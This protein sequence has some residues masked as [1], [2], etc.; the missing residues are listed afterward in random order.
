MWSGV[1]EVHKCTNVAHNGESDSLTS[2][3]G[4]QVDSF[5]HRSERSGRRGREF[6][7]HTGPL[8]GLSEAIVKQEAAA[9]SSTAGA[10]GRSRVS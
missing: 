4:E 6:N 10:G 7:E 5:A 2:K 3:V 8:P 9:R 1:K